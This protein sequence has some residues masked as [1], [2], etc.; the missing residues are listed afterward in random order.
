MTKDGERRCWSRR[1]T[2]AVGCKCFLRKRR[3][4]GSTGEESGMNGVGIS[5]EKEVGR[6]KGSKGIM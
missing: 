3:K 5:A 1:V 2:K 6:G 4:K